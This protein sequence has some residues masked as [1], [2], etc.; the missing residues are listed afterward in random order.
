MTTGERAVGDHVAVWFRQ[1]AVMTLKEFPQL[2]R[3]RAVFAYIVFIFTL[4][5]LI[6]A[7]QSVE[8]N[9]VKIIVNDADQSRVSRELTYR[10][11]APYF[12]VAGTNLHP[13]TALNWLDRGNATLL[14][15]IPPEHEGQRKPLP[16]VPLD[17]LAVD[18]R[19]DA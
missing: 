7:G 3:D 8:L 2:V 17:V 9:N 18:H 19:L 13:D 10:F 16:D 4:D 6:A 5:I 12:K 14:V 15:D 1:L 11:R